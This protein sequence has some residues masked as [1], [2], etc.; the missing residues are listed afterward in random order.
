MEMQVL[1]KVLEWCK[2]NEFE[3]IID[4]ISHKK[5][6]II[7]FTTHEQFETLW[8][9]FDSGLSLDDCDVSERFGVFLNFLDR[10]GLNS[11]LFKNLKLMSEMENKAV[12]E[13]VKQKLSSE[14]LS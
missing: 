14:G 5:T 6:E 12:Q 3:S 1:N 8:D 2:K 11:Q 4:N 13:I 7:K 9:C 10:F